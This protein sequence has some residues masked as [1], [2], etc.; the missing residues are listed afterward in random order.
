MDARPGGLDLHE[1]GAHKQP[2]V[3]LGTLAATPQERRATFAAMVFLL[4]VF[5]AAAPFAT[6]KLP[7]SDGFV[8]AVEAII[9]I[10]NLTTAA[11]L[12]NHFSVHRSR[13]LLALANVYLFTAF[14]VVGHT[15]SFPRAFAPDGLVGAGIQTTAWLR[16]V[17]QF[18]FPA[19]VIV[20]VALKDR[21]GDADGIRASMR[22]VVGRSVI[23]AAGL[24]L[25]ILWF[26]TAADKLLPSLLIDRLT[27]SPLVLYTG[28]VDTAVCAIALFL[29]L[30]RKA[31]VLDHLL[32]ISVAATT[33]EM[34]MVTFLSGGRFDVGWYTVRIFGVVAST[35]VLLA[36]LTEITRLHAKLSLALHAVERER[37]NKLLTAQAASAAIAHEIRQ[38][39]A[40][41]AASN[42]AALRFL[43]KAPPDLGQVRASLEL[44][45]SSC[46]QASAMIDD[47]RSLFRTID[48][49][50]APVDLNEVIVG[51]LQSRQQE[52]SRGKVEVRHELAAGLPPVRG[53]KTQLQEVIV[54]LVN[55]AVEAMATTTDRPRL[56]TL[57]TQRRGEDAIVVQVLDTGPGIDPERLKEIFDA[58]VTTKPQGTGLGLAICRMI[59]DH[60]GGELTVSSDGRSGALF[61]FVLPAMVS[62]EQAGQEHVDQRRGVVGG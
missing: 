28:A 12:F 41:I 58:F 62:A 18:S 16:I 32:A 30:T 34:A 39:L 52:L 13:A 36:L 17:W 31:S 25:G 20:Y 5:C 4:A 1:I 14:I 24:A 27:F 54:N 50:G 8:P 43:K 49:P 40:A 48:E 35:V 45:I 11:L 56:L 7:E 10:A 29:L 57:T 22:L 59:I 15:L 9:F 47:V 26:L 2:D 51:V 42:G 6:T 44:A 37:D 33:A 23:G 46:H 60:H 53:H 19:G 21:P 38:P 61:Q 3:W 55:N